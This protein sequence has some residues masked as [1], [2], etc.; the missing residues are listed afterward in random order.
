[1]M[2]INTSAMGYKGLI[3][4]CPLLRKVAIGSLDCT[5]D[6]VNTL[7]STCKDVTFCN[8]RGCRGNI[9]TATV[10]A[11]VRTCP[12]LSHIDLRLCDID[13]ACLRSIAKYC[14]NLTV[15][16][17]DSRDNVHVDSIARVIESCPALV[18]LVVVSGFKENILQR[19]VKEFNIKY[20]HVSIDLCDV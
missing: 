19:V 20:P 2:G 10:C 3:A 16:K 12:L 5:V 8:L 14:H 1:M 15:L 6:V 13:D 11:L 4:G 7:S 17:I 9:N 18:Q